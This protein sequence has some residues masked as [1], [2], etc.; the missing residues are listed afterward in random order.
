M[1]KD[2][3]LMH[4]LPKRDEIDEEVGYSGDKRVVFWRQPRNGMWIRV[5]LIAVIF[6]KEQEILD[7]KT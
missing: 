1:Q 6:Q 4:P 3:V 7:Y 5:A 2:A